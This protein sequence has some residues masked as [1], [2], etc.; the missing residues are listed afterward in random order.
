MAAA[1]DEE[2]AEASSDSSPPVSEGR[3]SNEELT[4]MATAEAS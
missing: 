3:L 2:E 4:M 1:A